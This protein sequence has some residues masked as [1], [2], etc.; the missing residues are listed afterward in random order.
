MKMSINN[1]VLFNFMLINRT[2][3]NWWLNCEYIRIVCIRFILFQLIV[4]NF[5][6][7]DVKHQRK[8]FSISH[9]TQQ[10]FFFCSFFFSF[11]CARLYPIVNIGLLAMTAAY[12]ENPAGN[13]CGLNRNDTTPRT[14]PVIMYPFCRWMSNFHLEWNDV[15]G[16]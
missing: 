4:L 5:A 12:A 11:V 1:I 15:R 9:S 16:S 3:R 6:H 10:L 8:Q 7:V 13:C 2:N 14:V